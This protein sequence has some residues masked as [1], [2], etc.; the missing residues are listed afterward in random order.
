MVGSVQ[1]TSANESFPRAKHRLQAFGHGSGRDLA[2]EAA[3][4]ALDKCGD[5]LASMRDT[6]EQLEQKVMKPNS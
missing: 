4:G 6:A 1:G 5:Q 2:F 3:A